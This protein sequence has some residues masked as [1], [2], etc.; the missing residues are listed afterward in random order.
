LISGVILIHGTTNSQRGVRRI[1]K[2]FKSLAE[3]PQG[4]G[5]LK[6]SGQNRY[7]TRLGSYRIIY[8]IKDSVLVVVVVKMAHRSIVYKGK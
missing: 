7:R 1:L 3:D 5:C 2:K 6:L 8:E 4:P